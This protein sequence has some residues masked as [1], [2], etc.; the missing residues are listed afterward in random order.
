MRRALADI[1]RLCPRW[2][3]VLAIGLAA[4]VSL[5][6]CG[7]SGSSDG[8][9]ASPNQGAQAGGPHLKFAIITHGNAGSSGFWAV[10]K[11][12]ANQAAK[13]MGVTVTYSEANLDPQKQA[14]LIDAAI[15]QKVNGIATTV[16]DPSALRGELNKAKQAGIPIV[17][18][19]SSAS[20]AQLQQLG[21]A[22]TSVGQDEVI[23]GRGAGERIK[24]LGAK[25]VL[26]PIHAQGWLGGEQRC[27][28]V[29]EGC[30]CRVDNLQ[31]ATTD[32]PTTEQAQLKSKLESNR[33]Y[34]F[35]MVLDTT[36]ATAAAV[37]AI[38]GANSQAKL[39]TFDLSPD[40]L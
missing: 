5:T 16:P 21:G 17:L 32:D 35:V 33:S 26:C 23:A 13:D 14:Q 12:G 10:Y 38:K 39:A 6:A 4:L 31:I 29:R 37:P 22:I 15:T 19:N 1:G 9:T 30:G 36:V 28:G 34:D 20:G 24:Q 27:Q 3:V 8:S 2:I 7:S 11:N 18:L 25:H 40:V